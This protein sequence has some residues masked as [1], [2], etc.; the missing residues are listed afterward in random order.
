MIWGRCELL[1][2]L[3]MVSAIVGVDTTMVAARNIDAVRRD[4]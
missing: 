1:G 2:A 4:T 3:V